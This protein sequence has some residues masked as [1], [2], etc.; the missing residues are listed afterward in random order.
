MLGDPAFLPA[1]PTGGSTF[2]VK[3]SDGL[4]L[5]AA[6][7][8]DA[9]MVA[10]LPDNTEFIAAAGS[11]GEW[12][13]GYAD[14]LSGWVSAGYLT[15]RPPLPQL[16]V[17][18]WDLVGLAGRDAGGNERP[19]RADDQSP[20]VETLDY[21]APVTVTEWVKGEEVHEG[22]DMWAKIGDG[23]FVYSRNVGRNAPVLPTAPPADAPTWG[24]WIDINLIQQLLTA[25]D[26]TTPVRTIEVTTGMAGWETPPGFYIDRPPRRERDDDLRRHRRGEPLPARRRALHPVLHRPRPRPPFRLVADQGDDRPPR[27]PRLRQSPARRRPLSSGTGR[28]S[29]RRSTCIAS[30]DPQV[31][32]R[33]VALE[34]H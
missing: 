23:R 30:G 20:I 33:R 27:Q 13:P 10:V 25:Y 1:P 6:P 5:R 17:A 11:S 24:K 22:S 28:S 32:D 3:A 19:P 16:Q 34:N 4:R 12:I 15:E 8:L 14:G 9:A 7:N 18:D 29:A 26:G 21:A 2:L 31:G